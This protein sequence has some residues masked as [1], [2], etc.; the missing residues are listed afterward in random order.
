MTA[1]TPTGR[2]FLS[3]DELIERGIRFSRVHIRRLERAGHFPMHVTL[4]AGNDVQSSIAWLV[5]EVE[6]WEAKRIAARDAKRD[7]AGAIAG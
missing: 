7:Q 1:I 5:D 4:G 3:Y 2:R 6:A